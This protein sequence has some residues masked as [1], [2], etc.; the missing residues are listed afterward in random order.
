MST[1]LS[2]GFFAQ[3]RSIGEELGV[4]PGDALAV[5]YSESGLRADAVNGPR[6]GI[7]QLDRVLL[8]GLGFSGTAAQF[9]ALD[10]ERQLP[11]V[12]HLWQRSAAAGLHS[13]VRLYQATIVPRSLV[14]GAE[15]PGVLCRRDDPDPVLRA[16]Y[17][18]FSALDT[19]GQGQIEVADLQRYLDRIRGD[20]RFQEAL[21]R[22]LTPV[23]TPTP[24]PPPTPTPHPPT[25]TPHPP[26][27]TPGPPPPPTPGPFVTPTPPPPP[28]PPPP[29][30]T[31]RPTPLTILSE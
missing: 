19:G 2:P 25:P 7:A 26:T 27:P 22:L 24:P 14:A 6:V 23:P 3:L 18:R 5:L 13:S 17:V 9:A 1:D 16:A 11:F 30:A 12:A 29:T 31:P 8:P 28:P 21:D 15:P 10:A 20:H 4:A